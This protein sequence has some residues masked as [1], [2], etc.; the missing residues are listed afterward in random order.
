ML[1]TLL[2]TLLRRYRVLHDAEFVAPFMPGGS[3]PN[4]GNPLMDA[5]AAAGIQ[6]VFEDKQYLQ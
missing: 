5:V 3:W 4:C 6:V 1:I 2:S